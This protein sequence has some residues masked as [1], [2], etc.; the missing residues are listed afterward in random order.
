MSDEKSDT[1]KPPPRDAEPFLARW[2]RRKRAEAAKSPMS[3]PGAGGASEA[4]DAAVATSEPP[5]DLATL[6]RIEDLTA[7]DTI[8][9]FLRKGVPEALRQ[10]ALRKAWSLDPAI[11]DFVE[12]AENQYDW[13]VAGG[14]PGFGELA[15]GTDLASLAD[16]AMGQVKPD[17]ERLASG[18]PTARQAE[19]AALDSGEVPASGI[20]SGERDVQVV[21]GHEGAQA[22][23][24]AGAGTAAPGQGEVAATGEPV[25]RPGRRRHGGALPA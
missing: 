21:G 7:S 4:A 24:D 11:R 17:I 2:S 9:T 10:L 1:D 3:P 8:E 13:N 22:Q 23:A 15:P 18:S 20:A 6:P 12:V 19:L 5:I 16:H 25:A 14:V